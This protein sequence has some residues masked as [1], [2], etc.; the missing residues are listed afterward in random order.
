MSLF[1]MALRQGSL[2]KFKTIH[3]EE[4]EEYVADFACSLKLEGGVNELLEGKRSFSGRIRICTR[5]LVFESSELSDLVKFPFLKIDHLE[6]ADGQNASTTLLV[7]SCT[8]LTIVPLN[9]IAGKMR[10]TRAHVNQSG[11]WKLLICPSY[12][13]VASK[14]TPQLFAL[15]QA[16]RTL[17]RSE[18]AEVV[19]EILAEQGLGSFDYSGLVHHR[20]VP[21][22]ADPLSSIRVSRMVETR[23]LV[24]VTFENLYFQPFPNFS[25][26]PNKVL[27]LANIAGV[28]RREY[29]LEPVGLEI[30]TRSTNDGESKGI[31]L[32]L[33]SESS[34]ENLLAVLPAIRA[35]PPPP[36]SIVSGLWVSGL[37]SNFDYLEFLNFAS[38]R[39]YNDLSQYPVFPWTLTAFG[40]ETSLPDFASKSSYRDFSRPAGAQNIEKVGKL[41]ESRA[42]GD[43]LFGTHYSTPAYVIYWLIRRFPECALRL[44]SGRFDH[45]ARLF[46]SVAGAWAAVEGGGTME[47]IP[48]FYSRPSGASD[49]LVNKLGIDGIEGVKLPGWAQSP[50][51][52]IACMRTALE[53][54]IVSEGLCEWIDLVFG[55]KSRGNS[56]RQADNLFH[57][58]T[59]FGSSS[60]ERHDPLC[61]QQIQEFGKTP[62]LLFTDTH[63]K[64]M[65]IPNLRPPSFFINETNSWR[66]AIDRALDTVNSPPPAPTVFGKRDVSSPPSA[67][68]SDYTMKSETACSDSSDLTGL[69][70]WTG[71]D[72]R[73]A[74]TG[75]DGVVRYSDKSLNFRV[76]A[77][78][79]LAVAALP[80]CSP[81]FIVGGVGGCLALVSPN[82]GVVGRREDAHLSDITALASGG[83]LLA[84][85]SIDQTLR[86]WSEDSGTLR[87]VSTLDA[88]EGTVTCLS[89]LSGNLL[90]SGDACGVINLW[91]LRNPKCQVFP[92]TPSCEFLLSSSVGVLSLSEW[93]AGYSDGTVVALDLRKGILGER[94]KFSV[95]GL[96]ALGYLGG[97]LWAA[98]G[99][100]DIYRWS[101]AE[102]RME[103]IRS[104]GSKIISLAGGSKEIYAL[105]SNGEVISLKAV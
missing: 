75:R 81:H 63:P 88:H 50:E 52:F 47:L 79:L 58:V 21:L 96:T 80:S 105:G 44:Q 78:P 102:R 8:C 70:V 82:R 48:E 99:I 89:F 86:I 14:V 15:W 92:S 27:S 67:T 13:G 91:D 64:R 19:K 71:D 95:E 98:G 25:N 31:L 100:G 51:H 76:S 11:T 55:C 77:C 46:T 3:L 32:L 18:S 26:R 94:N 45:K 97:H 56:A 30:V 84:S 41:K 62:D 42:G 72:K 54:P 101:S 9:V 29:R 16:Q 39:S 17:T 6:L 33:D 24:Q 1:L 74:V 40:P 53:S 34:R 2:S 93:W 37:L 66:N 68:K 28:F 7:G 69:A 103:I 90:L 12:H 85:G 10:S 104:C 38:G 4:G 73:W 35:P 22:L 23:G 87:D 61:K 59:Y 65:I 83:N 20:E 43:F 36:V 5:S 60:P 57:P 49:W